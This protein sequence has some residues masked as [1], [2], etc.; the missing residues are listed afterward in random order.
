MRRVRNG[1]QAAFRVLYDRYKAQLF[2]YCLRMLNDREAAMDLLQEIFIRIHNKRDHYEPGTNL[3]GW[4]H[5]IARNICLNA[6]RSLRD[7]ASFDEQIDYAVAASAQNEDVALRDILTEE[8]ARLP[9]IYRE[10]LILREY[11]GHSYD[12]ISTITGNSMSTVKFRIFK[13]REMLRERLS[14]K[15]GDHGSNNG[16]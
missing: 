13:A 8:I 16:K 3:G 6:R 15:L 4:I 5:T 10:A 9:D 11:E 1:D 12:E 14:W 7:H 2:L